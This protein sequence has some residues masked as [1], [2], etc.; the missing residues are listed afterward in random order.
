MTRDDD[1]HGIVMVG[2]AH[3]AKCLRASYLARQIRVGTSF[4]VRDTAECF[5]ALLLKL[6]PLEVQGNGEPAQ[7]A[8][9]I[10]LELFDAGLKSGRGFDPDLAGRRVRKPA[11]IKVQN[12]QASRAGS[13]QQS[14][15]RRRNARIMYCFGGPYR[16]TKSP[17]SPF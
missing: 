13:E 4:S 7:H 3:R 6:R 14:P 5:P 11:A 9:K 16:N 15:H 10:C 1:G 2:L 8:L 17:Q 12:A